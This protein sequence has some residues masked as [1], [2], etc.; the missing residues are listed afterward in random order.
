LLRWLHPDVNNG[1]DAVYAERV[2]SA[3]REVSVQLDID[4]SVAGEPATEWSDPF[5]D[6][7]RRAMP[8]N[9]RVP[10]IRNPTSASKRMGSAARLGAGVVAVAVLVALAVVAWGN[11]GSCGIFGIC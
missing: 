1:W 7:R 6:E 10:W 4:A 8:T 2:L 9:V 3:W 11:S 5:P